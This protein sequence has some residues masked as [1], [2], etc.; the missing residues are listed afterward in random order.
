MRRREFLSTAATVWATPARRPNIV[1]LFS[2]DQ[3]FDTIHAL[4]NRAIRT[5]NLDAL[6]RRGESFERAANMGGRHGA[7]CVASRAMLLSGQTLF[8][9]TESTEAAAPATLLGEHFRAHGYQT[10]GVGKWHHAPR[11]FNR[12]FDGGASILFG[13]MDDHTQTT[14][15]DY[16]PSAAYPKIRA[17]RATKFSSELFADET[18]AFLR[19]QRPDDRPFLVY[20]AFTAPHDPRIAPAEYRALYDERKIELPPNFLPQ[21]PFDNGELKVRDEL[22]AGLPRRPDEIRRH[23]ADYYAMVTHLDAH[24]GR[25]LDTLRTTGLEKNTIVVFAGDNG[26]ALG[27]HGLMGKQSLY[28]HSVRVPLIMAGPGL[29][30]GARRKE[31]AYLLD[32]YPTLCEL[33]K[34]PKPESVEGVSLMQGGRETLFFAYRH[35][36]RGVRTERW[37]LILYNVNGAQRMQ[38]FDMQTDPAE[39]R[40]LAEEPGR[41]GEIRELRELL[42]GWMRRTGDPQD[43]DQ[44]NWGFRTAN[45]GA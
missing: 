17:R 20:T 14:V 25:V 21:H 1:V 44:P 22:L 23:I 37:K 18:I 7:V 10:Y 36:M 28:D 31:F 27:Q 4:G 45:N 6:S 26:L 32:V 34:T 15:Q 3:R 11:L 16:D 2:D 39:T 13:G 19:R 38:L 43:L 30:A 5:P 33:T 42:R 9:A 41:A 8:R 29:K 35:L 24:I 40:N 12:C